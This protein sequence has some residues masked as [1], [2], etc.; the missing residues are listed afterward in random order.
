MLVAWKHSNFDFRST[1]LQRFLLSRTGAQLIA[2]NDNDP[3][4]MS[5]LFP[6]LDPWDIGGFYHWP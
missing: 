6:R 1:N 4:L 2:D 5:Y 3:G